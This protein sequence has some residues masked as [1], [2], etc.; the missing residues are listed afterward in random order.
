MTDESTPV[1]KW[2][3]PPILKSHFD[4]FIKL[5]DTVFRSPK[6]RRRPLLIYG[7]P[8][9]GKSLFTYAF[10]TLYRKN[11]QGKLT[12]SDVKR[13]NVSALAENIFESEIFGHKRG[14]FTGATADKKGFLENTKLLILEEIG[15]LSKPTQAKLLTFM[16]DGIYYRVG[17]TTPGKSADDIQIIAT[18]NAPLDA[19]HFRQDFLDRCYTFRVPALREY[20]GD[21]LY[22]LAYQYPDFFQTLKTIEITLCLAYNWPGNMREIEKLG[23]TRDTFHCNVDFFSLWNVWGEVDNLFKQMKLNIE[24]VDQFFH[25]GRLTIDNS[26]RNKFKEEI[27][28]SDILINSNH[29]KDFQYIEELNRNTNLDRTR[30][31]FSILTALL[32]ANEKADINLLDVDTIYE[33]PEGC[34]FPHSFFSFTSSSYNLVSEKEVRKMFDWVDIAY[35]YGKQRLMKK[36]TGEA[37]LPDS[38]TTTETNLLKSY[39][40]DL[41]SQT[42][43]NMAE[44]ARRSGVNRKTLDNKLISL[45]IHPTRKK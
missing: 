15:E 16:E 14:A 43:G 45:G 23:T 26:H 12:D 10:E 41:L 4:R 30:D 40:R 25:K 44:V 33:M 20:R 18:T 13:V 34:Y 19:D 1:P 28:F 8:G 21:I 3:L 7:A 37:S 24:E 17:D 11:Y 29:I 31:Y 39:Y 9:V 5:Y 38:C 22:I 42:N 2:I 6:K 32:S 35:N 27:A 36:T